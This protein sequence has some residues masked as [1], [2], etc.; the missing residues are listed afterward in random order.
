MTS[1]PKKWKCIIIGSGM[2]GLSAAKFATENGISPILLLEKHKKIGGLTHEFSR[3]K[4]FRF[5]SGLHY[6]GETKQGQ[7]SFRLFKWLTHDKLEWIQLPKNFEHFHFP[8]W[9]FSFPSDPKEL[10]LKLNSQFPNETKAIARFF[11]DTHKYSKR[12]LYIQIANSLPSSLRSFFLLVFKPW[13]KASSFTLQQYLDKHFENSQLKALLSSQWIDHGAIPSQVSFGYH[14]IIFQHYK[15]GAGYPIG[16]AFTIA[17][18]LRSEIPEDQLQMLGGQ[19]VTQILIENNKAIGVQVKDLISNEIRNE[20]ADDVISSAG[21]FNTFSSLQP[22]THRKIF[23]KDLEKLEDSASAVVAYIGLKTNP[24]HLGLD[25]SNHWLFPS[26]NHNE[27][28]NLQPGEGPIFIS[29]ASNVD[30]QKDSFICQLVS[31]VL[32][33]HFEQWAEL[34]TR[35]TEASY[36]EYKSLI[37]DRLI[38]RVN[39]KFPGF[40]DLIEIK[41]LGTPLTFNHYQNSHRGAFYGVLQNQTKLFSILSQP[42]SPIP[43]LYLAGQDSASVGIVGAAVGGIKAAGE[44]VGKRKMLQ[45]L[46]RLSG[47]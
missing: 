45:F 7:F 19:L 27:A 35:K 25:G 44:I 21:I 8:N 36:Q 37:L 4:K 34:K 24:Q 26:E 6:V 20:F 39:T 30:T 31:P 10:Q 13:F 14:S 1:Q 43:H 42:K 9:S 41:E 46:Q 15:Q 18:H 22:E 17:Q 32:Y 12:T 11:C 3:L 38:H 29:T 5:D 2:G 40:S 28:L 23:Q 47:S 16:G 33:G